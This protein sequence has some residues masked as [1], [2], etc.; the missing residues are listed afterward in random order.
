MMQWWVTVCRQKRRT[1][2]QPE[3]NK[4]VGSLRMSCVCKQGD[5]DW[6]FQQHSADASKVKTV[7]YQAVKMFLHLLLWQQLPYGMGVVLIHYGIKHAVVYLQLHLLPL[8]A[9]SSVLTV[10]QP[11]DVTLL[12]TTF[13]VTNLFTQHQPN[14]FLSLCSS[15][16]AEHFCDYLY[17]AQVGL[18]IKLTSE[19]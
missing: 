10:T 7:N 2:G 6:L 15:C 17:W 1:D 16:K 5:I 4:W 19:K 11:E 14:F 8:S 9:L 12:F 18:W 3:T 13:P